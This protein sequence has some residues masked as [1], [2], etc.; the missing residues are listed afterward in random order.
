MN[1]DD[2]IFIEHAVAVLSDKHR[3]S[4]RWCYVFQHNPLAVCKI[5]AVSK[6]ESAR[7]VKDG[8][9]ML[10]NRDRLLAK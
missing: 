6:D 4:V 5:I 8:R 7:L 9:Q 3:N 2:A 1:V 10:I